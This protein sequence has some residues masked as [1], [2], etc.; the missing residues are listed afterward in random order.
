MTI[1]IYNINVILVG[2]NLILVFLYK[3]FNHRKNGFNTIYKYIL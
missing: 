2:D 1:H 3:L